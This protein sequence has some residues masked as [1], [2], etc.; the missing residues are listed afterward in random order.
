MRCRQPSVDF[1]TVQEAGLAG[2]D[3]PNAWNGP[4]E[5]EVL[6]THDAET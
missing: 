4:P 5:N 6:F 2:E 3:D 1:V